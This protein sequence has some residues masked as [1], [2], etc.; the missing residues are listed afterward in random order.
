ME[1]AMHGMHSMHAMHESV[2]EAVVE[3]M[4]TLHHD[5]RWG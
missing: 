3:M 2:P 1:E 5:N 4:E